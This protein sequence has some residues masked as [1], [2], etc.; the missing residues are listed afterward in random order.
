[1]NPLTALA[2]AAL[3]ALAGFML[4]VTVGRWLNDRARLRQD[5]EV[6]TVW[7][8]NCSRCG[9]IATADPWRH[10]AECAGTIPRC[11]GCHQELPSE[12]AWDTHQRLAHTERVTGPE[13][14]PTW[15]T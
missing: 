2:A 5:E 9:V 11:G 7:L 4:A 12:D 8:H 14:H 13:D 6:L 15:A 1:M 10:A 3:W